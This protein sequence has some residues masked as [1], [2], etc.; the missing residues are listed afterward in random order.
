MITD[1]N[2]RFA[3]LDEFKQYYSGYPEEV[4]DKFANYSDGKYYF[5]GNLN[6]VTA[7]D[8][9]IEW[10]YYAPDDFLV[11]MVTPEGKLITSDPCQRSVI[12]GYYKATIEDGKLVL[13]DNFNYG[14]EL[15]K[16]AGRVVATIIIELLIGLIFGYRDR[17]SVRTIVKTNV[18]TQ[19]LLNV[20][21]SLADILF[22]ILGALF[23]MLRME[24]VIFVIEGIIYGKKLTGHTWLAWLYSL[25]ANAASFFLGTWL[26]T[27]MTAYM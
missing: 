16:F 9:K 10:T 26:L 20:F 24:I 5:W 11:V 2:S 23:I 1:G 17:D 18:F 21:V 27:I 7:E 15:L 14:K 8:N 13:K 3:N 19:I 6:K 4:I 25:I 22:G 12:A